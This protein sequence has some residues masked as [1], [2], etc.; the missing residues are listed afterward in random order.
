[1]RPHALPTGRAPA[2]RGA[3]R[4]DRP[5]RRARRRRR[6]ADR[7]GRHRGGQRLRVRRDPRARAEPHCCDTVHGTG[8]RGLPGNDDLGA[9]SAR[10]VFSALGLCPQTPGCATMLLGAPL[11]PAAVLDRPRGGHITISAPEADATHPYIDAVRVDGRTVDRSWTDARPVTRGG[12]LTYR[13]AAQANTTWAT[14]PAD[15]PR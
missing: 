7:P 9:M 10:Y 3:G 1:M 11:L 13:L 4:R 14:R 5:Q 2:P 8:P 6:A 12:A 15:L